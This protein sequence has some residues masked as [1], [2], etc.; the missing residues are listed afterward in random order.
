MSDPIDPVLSDHLD[1]WRESSRRAPRRHARERALDAMETA[2]ASTAMSRRTRS[3]LFQ[4]RFRYAGLVALVGTLAATVAVAA[5]GWNA[6]PGSALFVVRAAR[7]GVMLKL[8]GSDDAMLHLQFA[9][10]SLIEARDRIDPEQSLANARIEL[11]AA[12]AEL[13]LPRTSPIWARYYDDER[14]LLTEEAQ[15]DISE[16]SPSPHA[17]Q[18]TP[19]GGGEASGP[20]QSATGDHEDLS[21]PRSSTSPSGEADDTGGANSPSVSG[22]PRPDS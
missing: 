21:S 4:P 8:P 3:R 22:S 19:V 14:L 7:Q 9:E 17:G 6:P 10:Q 18:P 15:L 11:A 5:A 1:A 13:P 16:E 12:L 20:P 2:L